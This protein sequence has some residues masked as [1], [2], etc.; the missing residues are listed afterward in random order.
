MTRSKRL[1]SV[2]KLMNHRQQEAARRLGLCAQQLEQQ[3]QRLQELE[4]YREEYLHSFQDYMQVGMSMSRVSDYHHFI[5][6]LDQA[7]TQQQQSVY[8]AGKE[9]ESCRQEWLNQRCSVKAMD[10]VVSR[11]Q[12]DEQRLEGKREQHE[13]DESGSNA[14]RRDQ[15]RN[16]GF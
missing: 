11:H 3:R 12:A 10:K 16:G 4:T 2:V 15:V 1:N 9:Y 13:N 14:K 8:N 5:A 7:I 6:H